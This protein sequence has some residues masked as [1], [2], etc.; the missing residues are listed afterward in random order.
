MKIMN[1]LKYFF[2]ITLLFCITAGC[3]K[4]VSNDTS[5]TSSATASAKL[6]VLFD[7][8]QDNTG[9]VTI[10]PNGEGAISYD[11]YYGDTATTAVKVTAGKNTTHIYREGVYNVKIVGYNIDGKTTEAS[12]QLTVSFKAPENLKL[13]VTTSI[14]TV[15]VSASALYETFFKVYYGDSSSAVPVPFTP[16]LEG[17]TVTHTYAAAGTYIVKVVALSGGAA[18]TTYLDT[19]KV[20]KQLDLP[21]SFDDANVDYSLLDFGGNASSIAIDPANN[22]NKVMKVIKTAGA[23][24]WGGTTL[25][26]AIGFVSHLPIAAGNTRMSVKVYSP[27]AGL[28]IKLKIEDHTD[29]T[30]SV[31]AD[32]KTT[33]ANQWET[34]VFDFKNQAAGTAA[35]DL[36]YIFDK[37]SLF[38][39]F[40]TPGSGKIFYAD[41]LK[42]APP[43]LAQINLPVT[44]DD[45]KTD[46]TVTDFGGNLSAV[47]ADPMNSGNNVMKSIK[48]SGA[49]SWAGT[50]VGT[51]SGFATLI[52]ITASATKMSMRIYSPAA[53]LDIKLKIEDHNDGTHSVETDTKTT[54]ANQWETLT[55]DFSNPA[56]GTS[57]WNAAFKYDKASVFFDFGNSGDGKAYY[58]DDLKM[59]AAVITLMQIN[60]PVTFDDAAVDYSVTDFGSNQS[61]L[62]TDPAN[63]S[64]MVMKSIKTAGA[65]SWAG[66]TI[67]TALGFSAKIPV[68]ASS[69]KM[70]V[71]VYSPATGIDIK[72]K[73]EDHN[74]GTHSV[75]TD[76]KTRLAGQWET[77]VFDFSA[78]AAGT[79]AWNAAYSYD[80]ASIF[81]DFGNAGD[82]RTYYFD[83]VKF[84]SSAGGGGGL[85]QI[86][87]PVT[88]DDA[89]VDYTV[90]DFGNN[91]TVAAKDPVNSGNNVKMSTKP[92]GA[93]SWAGTT[94]GT[95]LGFAT[96]IP[97]TASRSKMSVRVY[98]PAAGLDIK[99]KIE[100]HNDPTRSVE[101]DVKSTLAN[102]WETLTFDFSTPAAGTA[103]LNAAFTYDKAS[104][105]FDFGNAGS[106]LIF[107][108]DDVKFL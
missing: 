96:A 93:Q 18:T 17:Q 87:L 85:S 50:T 104:I 70:S 97:V 75:E 24:V 6:S 31:E 103:A 21:V 99:L 51:A 23:E 20:A 77:L 5:F 105:F 35:L 27:A 91:L 42:M 59:A 79:S 74:D 69:T 46:Y 41:D 60:L 100:D 63:S 71:R 28:D 73:I 30:H 107:Y 48:T 57:A 83:D 102:Q 49:Q 39:D 14:L 98:S 65:Q 3:K 84:V 68:T 90:N 66:T 12:Q 26:G 9:L 32:A 52:P 40:G 34:L 16:F 53:G 78:P 36:S 56:A 80:K 82:G 88:F 61:S 106:G 101:C 1:A 15:N 8:T 22:T 13:T 25:G 76:T 45:V 19:I 64:N 37:A 55:F 94:I 86:S 2:S 62:A 29:A 4:D 54:V 7:I 81:F 72:L 47:I 67:G 33:L 43:S 10:T 95:P 92:A 108:W 58:F 89:T 11:I 44:F 38:F